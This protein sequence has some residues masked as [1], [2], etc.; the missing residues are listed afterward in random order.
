MKKQLKFSRFSHFFA[1][2]LTMGSG[3]IVYLL[4]IKRFRIKGFL[5]F[6][7]MYIAYVYCRDMLGDWL[8]QKTTPPDGDNPRDKLPR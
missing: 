2:M 6:I 3:L 5:I 8:L 7:V 1:L 4:V